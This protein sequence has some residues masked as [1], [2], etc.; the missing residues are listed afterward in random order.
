[1]T[2]HNKIEDELLREIAELRRTNAEFKRSESE[3]KLAEKKIREQNDFLH[4]V[5]ES[6]AHPFYVIDAEDYS[7]S[8]ANTASRLANPQGSA[9]CYGLTHLRSEPCSGSEYPCPLQEI[10]KTGK[11][12]IMEHIHFDK[13]RKPRNCEVHAYPIFDSQGK[14]VKMIEYFLDITERK[15]TEDE[16][17]KSDGL[18]RSV[19]STSPVGI[20]L[21][22]DRKIK[23]ANDAWARMFGFVNEEEFLGQSAAMLYPS[24]EEYEISGR[25]L[26]ADL[27]TGK[28]SH[29]ETKFRR[30]DGSVFNAKIRMKLID[31]LASE[32][33]AIAVITDITDQ[34]KSEQ[35][36]EALQAQLL[37][38]QKMESIGT[39]VGGIAHDFNNIFQIILSA[40]QLMLSEKSKDDP[41]YHLLQYIVNN[42]RGGADVV[43]RLLMFGKE[44]SI[45]PV[46]VDLNHQIRELTALISRTLPQVVQFDVDL[47]DGSATI[48]ADPNQI[49]QVIM[50]LAINASDAMPNGGRLRIATTSI[51]LDDEYCRSHHGAKPGNYVMLSVSDTGRGMDKEILDRVFDPFFSTKPKGSTRGTGLGLSVV[52]GI[53]EQHGGHITCESQLEEGSEFKVYFPTVAA[54]QSS[55]KKTV[56][57]S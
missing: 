17:R 53:V 13:D 38:S 47:A 3:H 10:R 44:A 11:P 36:K 21:T 8:L 29:V 40:S 19:L 23:W 14:F 33:L 6:L 24:D 20:G 32:K 4:T 46:S 48:H 50:N 1:M 16:L 57:S 39:L 22:Q 41:D 37:Q 55:E 56:P 34:L 35:E 43:N 18:L 2:S 45:R 28:V 15:R 7:L 12:V 27:E 25:A 30:K 31:P 54:P 51:L 26:Y 49:D 52:Q 9:T 5:L 42:V